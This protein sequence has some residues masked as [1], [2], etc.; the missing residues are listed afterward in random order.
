LETTGEHG[1]RRVAW[2]AFKGMA[3]NPLPWAIRLGCVSPGTGIL[4]PEPAM[5]AITMKAQAASPAALFTL[6]A[7]LARPQPSRAAAEGAARGRRS[8][9]P[10]MILIKL[11]LHPHLVL[12]GRPLRDRAGLPA[13]RLLAH[14]AR[15]G[16]AAAQCK[17]RADRRRAVP[18]RFGPARA[19]RVVHDGRSVREFSAAVAVLR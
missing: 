6:G 15:T 10:Q 16:G 2:Q 12:A 8:D 11:V 14:C 18:R 13:G 19:R 3:E 7:M 17:Q 4:P 5:H 1:M 9:V